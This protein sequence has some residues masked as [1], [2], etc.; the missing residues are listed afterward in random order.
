MSDASARQLITIGV[1]PE[2]RMAYR[3]PD[4]LLQLP[5]DTAGRRDHC[6]ALGEPIT[7]ATRGALA[8]FDVDGRPAL[9]GQFR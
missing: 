6:P 9:A 3:L 7:G 2:E 5:F 1:V 8:R 4:R